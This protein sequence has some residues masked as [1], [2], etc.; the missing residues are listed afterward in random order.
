MNRRRF[1][2]RLAGIAAVSAI[3]PLSLVLAAADPLTTAQHLIDAGKFE[4]AV[5]MLRRITADDPRNE[6]AFILLG[7]AWAQA[8]H[9]A[10]ALAAFRA[11]LRINPAD[12]HTRMLAD[13]LAQRP[14][15]GETASRDR[16]GRYGASRQEKAALAEREAFAA[17]QGR[18]PPGKGPFRLVIDAG[19]GGPDVGGVGA[20]GLRE[21]DVA[22][23]LALQTARTIQGAG[24]GVAVFLTRLSDV[25][26]SLAARGACADLYGADLFFSLHAPFVDDASVSGMYLFSLETGGGQD[27]VARAVAGFENRLAGAMPGFSRTGRHGVEAGMLRGGMLGRFAGQSARYA[28]ILGKSLGAGPFSGQGGVGTAG[29]SVLSAV[30]APAVF[31]ATGFLSNTRDE[32]V[33]ADAQRRRDLAESLARGILEIV[34]DAGSGPPD[35]S[36]RL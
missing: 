35:V 3:S 23:D 4:E 9:P 20:A 27:A 24:L 28:A 18:L 34:R 10:Q 12:T 14:L 19:H 2:V 22:L 31:A 11:A 1:L 29:L 33:L 30:D 21:K 36:P 25:P 8:D 6:R 16:G 15:P 32:A 26:L 17:G 5:A 13:I 7:R